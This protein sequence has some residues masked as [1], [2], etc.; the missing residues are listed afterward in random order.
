[1]TEPKEA[2]VA[3]MDPGALWK[4]EPFTDRKVGVIRR[5]TPVKA[6]GSP[7]P[8]RKTAFVGEASLMTPAGSLPLSFEIP[9]DNLE[10][11]VAG[12]GPAL[13]EALAEAMEEL[14]ELRRRAAS[15]IVIPQGGIPPGGLAGKLKLP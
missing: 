8:S 6:D 15:Q 5:M 10:T 13:E 11:A 7:D 14:K 3:K 4:E 12:Y 9:A 1:M 2:P